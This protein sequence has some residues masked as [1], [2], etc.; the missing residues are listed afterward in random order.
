MSSS[1]EAASAVCQLVFHC[2]KFMRA[3]FI[4]QQY[5]QK[6]SSSGSTFRLAHVQVR[7]LVLGPPGRCQPIL[8]CS[9]RLER[10]LAIIRYCTL[11]CCFVSIRFRK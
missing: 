4:Y 6:C 2:D 9:K 5:F 11:I 1:N 3:L 10:M 8:I 7:L